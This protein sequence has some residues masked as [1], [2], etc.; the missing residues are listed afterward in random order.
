MKLYQSYLFKDKDPCIDELRT[1]ITKEQG[2]LQRKDLALVSRNGG[3][4]TSC[5]SAWFFGKTKR[6]QNATLEA[7]GRA[8][9]FKREWVDLA[10]SEYK[11]ILM[12]AEKEREKRKRRKKRNGSSHK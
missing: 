5:L 7:A 8:L 4:T 1:I 12:A 10:P 2:S 6:P 9:G 3:P 11:K